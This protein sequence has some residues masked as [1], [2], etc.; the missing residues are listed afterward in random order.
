[1]KFLSKFAE[2]DIL[3]QNLIYKKGSKK[4]INITN[5]LIDEQY[6]FCAYTEKY[7]ENL[8]SIELEHFNSTIKYK[9]ED[10]YYNYYA[11]IRSINILKKDEYFFKA[12]NEKSSFFG[13]L[14]FHSKEE[15]NKRIRYVK[16]EFIFEEVDISDVEAREFI[17]FLDLNN[18]KIRTDRIN[19]IKVLKIILDKLSDNELKIEYFRNN[20]TQL[21]F[22]TT[23]ENEFNLD[24]SEFYTKQ[25]QL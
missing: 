23:I 4:N 24:L 22:I 13:S 16:D 8:D 12:A 25:E 11:V 15:L 5:I 21:K 7:F 6:K 19:H 3:K 10:N 1:M 17:D 2:S 14:F 9:D 20:R 18:E